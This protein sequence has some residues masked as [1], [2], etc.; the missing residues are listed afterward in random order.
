MP[1][2]STT[3]QGA[4]DTELRKA[5]EALDNKVIQCLQYA[6][7]SAVIEARSYNGKAYRDQTSNLRSSTG[8]VIVKDGKVVATSAFDKAGSG[9]DGSKGGAGGKAYAKQLASQFPLGYVLIVV[10][11]MEYASYVADK[12]YNVLDSSERV[13]RQVAQQLLSKLSKKK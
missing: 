4:I 7:E 11:G 9:T 6:G 12:G 1:I 8:Y 10:A 13:A 2:K 3:P 5:L